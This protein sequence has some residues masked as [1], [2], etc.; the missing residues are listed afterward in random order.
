MGEERRHDGERNDPNEGN[1]ER[2]KYGLLKHL[3]GSAGRRED[4]DARDVEE[5]SE[6]HNVKSDGDA[7]AGTT[8]QHRADDKSEDARG[9]IEVLA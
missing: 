7:L 6:P 2:K 4:G 5:E 3:K 8:E 9:D 1:V